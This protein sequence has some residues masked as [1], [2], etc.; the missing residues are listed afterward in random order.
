MSTLTPA[1]FEQSSRTDGDAAPRAWTVR[2]FGLT[3]RGH[4]RDRNE[5]HF[6]IAELTKTLHV[7]HTSLPQPDV[8]EGRQ[9]GYLFL[10]ADGMGGHAGGEV[11]SRLATQAVEEFVLDALKWFLGLKGDEQGEVVSKLQAALTEADA[12]ILRTVQQRPVLHGMGT[13]MT[14]AFFLRGELFTAHAG[15]SR[16]ALFRGGH[17]AR[18]T[19]DHTLAAE[20]VR[21]GK[22]A[23]EQVATHKLRHVVTNVVGGPQP[24][25]FVEVGHVAVEPGDRLL[26]CTDG[27]SDMVPEAEI[28]ETLR[29]H[30]DPEDACH[31]LMHE[32]LDRGGSDNV[33]VVVAAFDAG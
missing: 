2:A 33:T 8:K 7:H 21:R 32:A 14:L 24:G 30:A 11:A 28:A 5:D 20:L 13:T 6:L 29:A 9:H 10:V 15:D 3:D 17:L 22:L 16:A 18:L 23:P 26:L 19:Q 25:V 31:V 1:R 12:E 27:L 4:V